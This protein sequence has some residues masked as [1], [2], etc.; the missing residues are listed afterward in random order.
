MPSRDGRLYKHELKE[1]IEQKKSEIIELKT[2]YKIAPKCFKNDPRY[3]ARNKSAVIKSPIYGWIKHHWSYNT[4]DATDIIFLKHENHIRVHSDLKYD[5]E[6]KY[7]FGI[8][9][10]DILLDTKRKHL[11]YIVNIEKRRKEYREK[12]EAM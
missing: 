4:E 10:T 5:P 2:L 3:I 9:D 11:R 7:Y 12:Y 1:L 8:Y 6:S